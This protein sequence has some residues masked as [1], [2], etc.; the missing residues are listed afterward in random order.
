MRCLYFLVFIFT[1]CAGGEPDVIMVEPNSAVEL[2]AAVEAVEPMPS[3]PTSGLVLTTLTGSARFD[4]ETL[5]EGVVIRRPEDTNEAETNP[6]DPSSSP[7]EPSVSTLPEGWTEVEECTLSYTVS[8]LRVDRRSGSQEMFDPELPAP[9]A[10]HEPLPPFTWRW[11]DVFPRFNGV[12]I[13]DVLADLVMPGYSDDWSVFERGMEWT[14][15]TRC[16]ELPHGSFLLTQPAAYEMWVQTVRRTLWY[17]VEQAPGVRT[18]VGIRGAVPGS[19]NWHGNPKNRFNDTIVL[20]WRDEME[21]RHVR[22]FPMTADPGTYGFPA[23]ES[24]ALYPNRHYP[25]TNGWHRGYNALQIASSGY[26][27]RDDGNKNGHWDDDRNGW[28]DGGV[29]DRFRGGSGHNIHMASPSRSLDNQVVHNWSAGCQVIPG[30]ANWMEFIGNA[31]TGTGNQVDYFLMDVRDIADSVWTPCESERGTHRC[32]EAIQDLP[33]TLE[34][35]T[36]NSVSD[37]FDQYNCSTANESGGEYVYVLNIRGEG[38]LTVEV[39]S[40]D[41]E[42]DPD[43]HL[44]SGD[45]AN[46][47]L[48]RAHEQFAYDITPGR[49]LLVVDSW[50]NA[51][52]DVLDGHYRVQISLAD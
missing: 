34:G 30:M 22:E 45:D 41:P 13:D 5:A 40:D 19:L 18:V 50:V 49:Y 3:E 33:V 6:E 27:V 12:G 26:R 11:S 37:E 2:D 23:N 25:Y 48:V 36:R 42:A 29:A 39:E 44:L 8:P 17:E 43:I 31:W 47:C 7:T 35:D 21:Q 15:P 9:G 14:E 10:S 32:P 24:S 46:A 51:D 4:H 1:A 20:L 52:D 16:Y 28:L 38:T